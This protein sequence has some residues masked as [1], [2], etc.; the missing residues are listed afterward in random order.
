MY[1]RVE[2][3]DESETHLQKVLPYRVRMDISDLRVPKVRFGLEKPSY[4]RSKYVHENPI[5]RNISHH[6]AFNISPPTLMSTRSTILLHR[7][8][9]LTTPTHP[10]IEPPPRHIILTLPNPLSPN[11]ALN[12]NQSLYHKKSHKAQSSNA[13]YI[14]SCQST[15]HTGVHKIIHIKPRSQA[16]DISHSN[17]QD[18]DR[19]DNDREGTSMG[20]DRRE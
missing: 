8:D 7:P 14:R 15:H 11:S 2:R 18:K 19:Y 12:P 6:L 5:S 20:L 4:L 1:P 10:R 9:T 17:V 3:V 16:N 13:K